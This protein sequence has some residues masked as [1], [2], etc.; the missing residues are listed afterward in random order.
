MNLSLITSFFKK[1]HKNKTLEL[2]SSLLINKLKSVA[3]ENKLGIFQNITIYH[4]A[5]NFIIPL[6]IVDEKRGIFLFE[7]KDWSY[8]E[9]KNSKIEKASQQN[10]SKDTL[11]FEK[12]H[13]FIRRKFNELTHKEGVPIFNYLLMENLN[14]D[15][16]KHLDNSFKELLPEDK[17]M[18]NDL[19]Q[20]EI[21]KKLM[22]SEVSAKELPNIANIMGTLLIQY[23]ILD[24]GKNNIYLA[25]QEQMKF[26][27]SPLSSKYILNAMSK[28]GKT[29]AILLK[30][31]LEKLKN[32]NLRILIV[33]PTILACDM[34]KKKLLDIVEY[35][36]IELDLTSI[37]ILTPDMAVEK[38][39]KIY[40]LLICDDSQLYSTDF[41]SAF[42]NAKVS[43][44]IVQNNKDT[45]YSFT[46]QFHQ[47]KKSNLYKINQHAKALQLIS[48]LLNKV[49]AKDILVVCS[50]SSQE[51][52]KDDLEFFIKDKLEIIDSSKNL[53][54]QNFD[55][56]SLALY[57]DIDSLSASH[58]IL[59][60][61]CECDRYQLESAYNLTKD[62]VYVL[63]EDECENINLIK[64]G[65]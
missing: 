2:P 25:T 47:I 63:Y 64:N 12:S 8:N 20:D 19:S 16:Y 14:E 27:D 54:S 28:S 26:I 52:L 24:V 61:I 50:S 44:I 56:L 43:C 15:E 23:A 39:P 29:S 45:E 46:K 35:A 38:S 57:K 21:L 40:D 7:H 3:N 33:K 10:A 17:I 30:A 42:S 6:L 62:S 1:A 9:L 34:L 41:V 53:I 11:A 49:Q 31:V 18:F 37:E 32:P 5:K 4:H 13:D 36:I 51:K 22:M 48:S 60:D 59:M 55:G 65:F 58:V